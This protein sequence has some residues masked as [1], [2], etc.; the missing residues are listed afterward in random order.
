MKVRSSL[1]PRGKK[2]KKKGVIRKGRYTDV[3]FVKRG[4]TMYVV[5]KEGSSVGARAKLR[6]PKPKRKRKPRKY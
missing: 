1:V 4:G 3:I 5:P 6:Q 2:L